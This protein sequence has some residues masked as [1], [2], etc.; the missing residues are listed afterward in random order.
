[1]NWKLIIFRLSNQNMRSGR[2]RSLNER[3]Q[4]HLDS[5]KKQRAQ[6]KI[7]LEWFDSLKF[8]KYLHKKTRARSGLS[9]ANLRHNSWLNVNWSQAPPHNLMWNKYRPHPR[10]VDY[11]IWCGSLM[12]RQWSQ[13][14]VKCPSYFGKATQNTKHPIIVVHKRQIVVSSSAPP[15]MRI[16]I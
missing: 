9:S 5:L 3:T 10:N 7:R 1:M 6:N 12:T 13:Q 4:D 2:Y 8:T 11:T 14:F 15:A 16:S